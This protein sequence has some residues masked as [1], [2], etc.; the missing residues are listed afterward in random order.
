MKKK[1]DTVGVLPIPFPKMDY[2]FADFFCGC[3]GFSLGFIQAGMKCISAMDI[4][5]EPIASYWYNLCYNTWSHLWLDPNNVEA[6]KSIRK[7]LKNGET[8]N[9]LFPKGVPD[10]WLEDPAPS[11][12]LN[13]FCYSILDMDPFDW[14]E[15]C[16]VRPG[17]I[18][19]FIGG[20]PCQG[21]ST[22]NEKR[23]VYD[24]RNQLPLRYLY[25]A[26][27]AK[28]DYVL[29]E[30]VPGLLSLGKKK[31]EKEGLFVKWIRDAF[32]DA[33]YEMSYAVHNA[34][35]YG[36]P[37]NR[38]RV[39]FIGVRHGVRKFSIPEGMYGE[40]PGKIPYQW[41]IEAIMDLPPL[42]AGQ[43]WGVDTLHPYGYNHKDGFVI[44]PRCLK[45]NRDVRSSCIHCGMPLDHPINGGVVRI[46]G[47]GTLID[48]KKPVDNDL[49]S[50][51]N[52]LPK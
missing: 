36:V 14:M 38:K 43:S 51:Y 11:P 13:L 10:N 25:Y 20:P 18:K 29:I 27:V 46:P 52:L 35:D 9:W 23:S 32:E 40:G 44:C 19:V 1:N 22:A 21:F 50:K 45:Y 15:N 33:G 34:A 24:E 30:N 7:C 4:S 2:T 49:L 5:P 39:L 3:G 26:K 8:S 6:I 31:G 37:Q 41:V 47:L 17:D 28:P 42:K 12:C 16:G 48:T